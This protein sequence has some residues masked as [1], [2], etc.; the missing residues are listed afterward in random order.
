MRSS[1]TSYAHQGISQYIWLTWGPGAGTD[2]VGT[3]HDMEDFD[4]DV[5]HHSNPPVPIDHQSHQEVHW[6]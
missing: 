5:A 6:H 2:D 3:G 1:L 4:F